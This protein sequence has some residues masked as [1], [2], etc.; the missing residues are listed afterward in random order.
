M[1]H[2]RKMMSSTPKTRCATTPHHKLSDLC[3]HWHHTE[4]L[5]QQAPLSPRPYPTPHNSFHFKAL[6]NVPQ[7]VC[8]C[9]KLP[10]RVFRRLICASLWS[11]CSGVDPETFQAHVRYCST[12]CK[13]S[14]STGT[15]HTPLE[16]HEFH[17]VLELPQICQQ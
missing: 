17:V 16:L 3:A 11:R 8:I 14:P 5:T 4:Q 15:H 6:P 7:R 10:A 2:Q 9:L 12:G 1:H 13:V